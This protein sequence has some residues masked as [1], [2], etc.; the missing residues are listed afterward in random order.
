MPAIALTPDQ[1]AIKKEIIAT[2]NQLIQW[3]NLLDEEVNRLLD[4]LADHCFALHDALAKEGQEPRYGQFV[5]MQR[6]MKPG[7]REFYRHMYAAEALLEFLE[8]GPPPPK[9]AKRI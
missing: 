3:D 8:K 6:G 7:N 5:S 1:E 4:V 9:P 2:L